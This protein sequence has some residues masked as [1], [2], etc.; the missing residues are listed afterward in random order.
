MHNNIIDDN[1]LGDKEG[2]SAEEK[3]K[4]LNKTHREIMLL[5]DDYNRKEKKKKIL[6]LE[7]NKLKN[8]RDLIDIG[9][10]EKKDSIS[11]I[12]ADQFV[13]SS[14]LDVKKKKVR[15]MR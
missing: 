3:K 11:R 8:D 12:E 9:M 15:E 5:E 10:K 1:Q 7:F 6:E 13:L 4:D 14:E 2:K